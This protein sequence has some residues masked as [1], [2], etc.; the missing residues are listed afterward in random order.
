M[1]I[2]QLHPMM[3]QLST[4]PCLGLSKTLAFCGRLRRPN[5]LKGCLTLISQTKACGSE[6]K[7]Q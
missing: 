3:L 1:G 7:L 4:A 5:T 2:I 6:Q